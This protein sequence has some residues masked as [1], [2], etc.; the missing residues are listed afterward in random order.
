MEG[1]ALS[2]QN[3]NEIFESV[4]REYANRNKSR[5]KTDAISLEKQS[6]SKKTPKQ[7]GGCCK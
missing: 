4:I 2:G 3:I 6:K 7:T 1:S 5:T